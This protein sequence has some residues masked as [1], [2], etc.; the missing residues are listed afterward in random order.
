MHVILL[1]MNTSCCPL[2]ILAVDPSF[3]TDGK[4]GYVSIQDGTFKWGEELEQPQL[5]NINLTC[6]P[7]SLTMIVGAVGSGKSSLLGA[8]T[9]QMTRVSGTVTIAGKMAYV[10]QVAWIM[11]ATLRENILMGSPMDHDRCATSSRS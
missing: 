10:P 9:Q 5:R 8:L 2:Q 1:F 11:N 7:G 4:P 6:Q 3:I